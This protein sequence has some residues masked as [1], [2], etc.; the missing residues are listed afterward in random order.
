VGPTAE[1]EVTVGGVLAGYAPNTVPAFHTQ[2]VL[3]ARFLC[4]F[5]TIEFM[6]ER[7]DL[8]SNFFDHF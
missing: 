5:L 4:S 1:V 3:R 6:F 7:S 8:G 2:R